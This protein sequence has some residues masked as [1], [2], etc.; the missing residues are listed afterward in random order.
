M[1]WMKAGRPRKNPV[2]KPAPVA[3]EPAD[4]EKY[5][6]KELTLFTDG[7]VALAAAVISQCRK[8]HVKE[9]PQLFRDILDCYAD[10]MMTRLGGYSIGEQ[11][12]EL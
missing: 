6:R 5:T 12:E 4:N 8:D 1:K 10:S 9:E 11:E 3:Q 2:D 7:Y